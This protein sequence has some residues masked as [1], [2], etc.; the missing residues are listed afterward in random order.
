MAQLDWLEAAANSLNEDPSFRK[1]GS[2]DLVLGLKAGRVVRVV[3]F[4]AFAITDVATAD[5]SALRDCE[6]VIE[7]SPRE[8]TA[9]LRRRAKGTGPSLLSLDLDRAI[10]SAGSPLQRLKFQRYHLTLQ[11]L[12]DQ[13]AREVA[14]PRAVAGTAN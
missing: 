11:A 12:V 14:A 3:T 8:W 10:V 4:E 9:Y 5:E 6:L 1:L 13:G 7:M 2:A